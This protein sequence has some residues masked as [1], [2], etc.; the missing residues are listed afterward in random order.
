M[1]LK[2]IIWSIVMAIAI[3][4]GIVCKWLELKE[5][6]AYVARLHSDPEFAKQQHEIH[7]NDDWED[8]GYFDGR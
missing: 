7:K 5:A 3:V 4:F 1:E 2:W 8:L 6:D